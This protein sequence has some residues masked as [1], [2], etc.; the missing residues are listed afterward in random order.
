MWWMGKANLIWVE[1]VTEAERNEGEKENQKKAK[2]KESQLEK[3]ICSK[4]KQKWDKKTVS[5]MMVSYFHMGF[6]PWEGQGKKHCF[7]ASLRIC[8]ELQQ[9]REVLPLGYAINLIFGL[10]QKIEK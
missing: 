8:S 4:I 2:I 9:D 10:F 3:F 1:S 6:M 7:S 5:D